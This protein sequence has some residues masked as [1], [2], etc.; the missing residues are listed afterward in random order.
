MQKLVVFLTL[1]DKMR[2][3]TE[4]LSLIFI[5]LDFL[6]GKNSLRLLGIDL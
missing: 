6:Q 3:T 2:N 4:I 5:F 1:S